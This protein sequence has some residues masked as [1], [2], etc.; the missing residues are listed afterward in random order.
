M[1]AMLDIQQRHRNEL[2]RSSSLVHTLRVVDMGH[3]KWI[4]GELRRGAYDGILLGAE[5]DSGSLRGPSNKIFPWEEMEEARVQELQNPPSL[6]PI[7]VPAKSGH[8]RQLHVNI[9]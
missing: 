6:P 1:Q 2:Q 9:Y 3:A 4:L 7:V 8:E 5:H